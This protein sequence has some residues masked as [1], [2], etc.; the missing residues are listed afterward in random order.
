MVNVPIR[1]KGRKGKERKGK[2][3]KRKGKRKEIHYSGSLFR[4]SRQFVSISA[5]SVGGFADSLGLGPYLCG[6]RMCWAGPWSA[7][8]KWEG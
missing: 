6:K 7:C 8:I 3:K 4:A 1:R 5:H 2:K